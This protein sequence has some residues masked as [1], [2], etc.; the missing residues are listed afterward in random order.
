MSK[1]E[2]SLRMAATSRI[3]SGA[4][5]IYPLK[6]KPNNYGDGEYC[7]SLANDEEIVTGSMM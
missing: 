2:E 7:L 5:I 4:K 1:L 6:W 3:G